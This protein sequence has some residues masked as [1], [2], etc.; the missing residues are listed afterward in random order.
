MPLRVTGLAPGQGEVRVLVVD[1]NQNNREL[2]R[3]MLDPLGFIVDEV[4]S[5]EEALE[6]VRTWVPGII[7]MDLVLPGKDG[8]ETSR[9]LRDAYSKDSI[10]IIGISASAF[11]TEKQHFLDSGI[12]AFLAKPF[13]QEELYDLLARYAGVQFKSAETE[14]GLPDEAKNITLDKMS[15][16]W[17]EQF[18][19]A[20]VWGNITLIR[21]LGKEANAID[22]ALSAYVTN[23]VALY[24]LDGLKIFY[25]KNHPSTNPFPDNR[26]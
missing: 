9:I 22:P 12:N 5:G 6:K 16:E 19:Q 11:D 1:D 15:S 7:L 25:A 10:I 20:L 17:I 14:T 4:L 8:A 26:I 21:A 13:R 18:N 24:N 23:Q 3:S 2:L